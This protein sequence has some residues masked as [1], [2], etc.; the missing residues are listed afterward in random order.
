MGSKKVV[1]ILVAVIVILAIV[2]F[3]FS[4]FFKVLFGM[5]GNTVR[6]IG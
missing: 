6:I 3:V 4:D 1:L 5:T 2:G